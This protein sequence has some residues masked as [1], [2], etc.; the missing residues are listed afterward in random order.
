M[1]GEKV[2]PDTYQDRRANGG[3]LDTYQ[4]HVED[5]WITNRAAT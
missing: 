4:E 2:L 1:S 3:I 5:P